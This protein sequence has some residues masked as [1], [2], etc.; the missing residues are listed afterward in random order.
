MDA[1]QKAYITLHEINGQNQVVGVSLSPFTAQSTFDMYLSLLETN[2]RDGD[3]E[4]SKENTF[5][6]FSEPTSDYLF[7]ANITRADE[8]H[9]IHVKEFDI[10]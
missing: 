1:Q 10:D 7:S 5:N 2:W 9:Y 3:G 4:A 6:R 8:N